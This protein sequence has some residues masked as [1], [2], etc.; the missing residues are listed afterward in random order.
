L[1]L[2]VFALAG[3]VVV[4]IPRCTADADP[5][6]GAHG[7]VLCPY[8]CKGCT[9]PYRVY[10][11]WEHNGGEH[12]T[13]GADYYCPTRT[14]KVATMS[15]ADLARNARELGAYELSIAPAAATYLTFL[16]LGM[17][18]LPWFA[19]RGHQEAM[20]RRKA[21]DASIDALVAKLARPVEIAE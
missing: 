20:M 19:F 16:L 10:T 14:N 11:E 1:F 18:A 9:G 2:P 6:L 8:R 13:N 3:L 4:T 21:M 7:Y 12:S 17:L 15:D 5:F